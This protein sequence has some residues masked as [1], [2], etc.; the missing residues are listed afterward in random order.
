M[1][2]PMIIPANFF[3]ESAPHP[4][5]LGNTL[6]KHATY[7]NICN[8]LIDRPDVIYDHDYC[9]L[10]DWCSQLVTK[11]LPLLMLEK[12]ASALERKVEFEEST[13]IP[14]GWWAFYP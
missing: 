7:L 4:S 5:P 2:I 11:T 3:S 10:S 14:K 1:K 9:L 12:E 8:K 13:G 6:N